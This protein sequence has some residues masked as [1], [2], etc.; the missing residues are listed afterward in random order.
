MK[1]AKHEDFNHK[2]ENPPMLNPE[3]FSH[4]GLSCSTNSNPYGNFNCIALAG[5]MHHQDF[6][7]EKSFRT[8]CKIY[9]TVYTGCGP[10]PRIC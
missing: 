10:V 3:N 6:D 1:I 9:K 8:V 2:C 7:S 5:Y 4:G